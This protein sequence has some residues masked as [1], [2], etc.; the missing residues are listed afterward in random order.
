MC[1]EIIMVRKVCKYASSFLD[2]III[3]ELKIA[4]CNSCYKKNSLAVTSR[5][6][7]D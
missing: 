4:K 3:I 1:H 7:W 2:T 6:G 5:K